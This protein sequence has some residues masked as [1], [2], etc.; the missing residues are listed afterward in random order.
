MF[1]SE[2]KLLNQKLGLPIKLADMVV[3]DAVEN[4]I[5]TYNIKSQYDAGTLVEVGNHH[6]WTCFKQE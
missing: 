2:I 3:K 1:N 6:F 4:V 5:K